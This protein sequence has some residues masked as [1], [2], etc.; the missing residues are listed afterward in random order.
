MKKL[1][2][3]TKI[4]FAALLSALCIKT[5]A[6]EGKIYQP[7]N[8]ERYFSDNQGDEKTIYSFEYN[9][10]GLLPMR[11]FSYKMVHYHY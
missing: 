9:D 6:Q 1:H 11:R 10:E 3:S 8:I 2:L 4:I 7:T 5:N